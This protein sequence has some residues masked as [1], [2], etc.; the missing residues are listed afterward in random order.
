METKRIAHVA[1]C[2]YGMG[3]PGPE[4]DSRFEDI[5]RTMNFVADRIVAERPDLV[6][7]AGDAFKDGRVML[8]RARREIGT[9][10]AWLAR[11]DAAGLPVIVIAGTPSHDSRPAYE[12]M[13]EMSGL[14]REI[15]R[16]HV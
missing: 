5:V 14:E 4:P 1:D 16:A 7:F 13:R 3:Y 6:V 15:G 12:L 2:H 9:F 11:L 10:Y 8:D